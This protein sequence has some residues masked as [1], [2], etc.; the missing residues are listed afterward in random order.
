MCILSNNQ[1]V[2][3]KDVGISLLEARVQPG[4]ERAL[5]GVVARDTPHQML[6]KAVAVGGPVLQAGR[7]SFVF[8]I[9]IV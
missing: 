7:T 4:G 1:P 8:A 5:G 6:D 3:A 2:V 9:G